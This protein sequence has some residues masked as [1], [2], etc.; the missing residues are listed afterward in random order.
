MGLQPSAPTDNHNRSLS[1]FVQGFKSAV[2]ARIN[3]LRN[4]P[5]K[6]VWQRSFHDHIIRNE[7]LLHAIREYIANNPIHW[8]QD[9]DN[10]FHR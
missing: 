4:M 3:T 6:P 7:R 1:A 5:G 2:T 8:E 9:M 10:V